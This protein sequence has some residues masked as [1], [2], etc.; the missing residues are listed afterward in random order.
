V[1][2]QQA[3]A[4]QQT[5]ELQQAAAPQPAMDPNIALILNLVAQQQPQNRPN[6]AVLPKL[7]PYDGESDLKIFSNRFQAYAREYGWTLLDQASKI[8]LFLKGKA[9]SLYD[10]LSQEDRC[11][12]DRIWLHLE[13]NLSPSESEW[14]RR[15]ESLTPSSNESTRDFAIKL[16]DLYDRANPKADPGQRTRDLKSR[17]KGFLPESHQAAFAMSTRD[18]SWDVAVESIAAALPTLNERDSGETQVEQIETYALQHWPRSS[19]VYPTNRRNEPVHRPHQTAHHENRRSS[20]QQQ[21]RHHTQPASQRSTNPKAPVDICH[22]CQ[23]PGH[24]ARDC[25]APAPVNRR[26]SSS[27]AGEAREARKD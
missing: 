23:E 18:S 17:I 21:Y 20:R 4:Q 24:F 12:M 6:F 26:P 13:K 7:D 11:S 3:A 8:S 22:R 27:R 25:K 14:L 9:A 15:F 5:A 19:S 2:L 16:A 10:R 1:E